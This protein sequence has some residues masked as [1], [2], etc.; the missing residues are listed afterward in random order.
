MVRLY[1][2]YS[3]FI[4]QLLHKPEFV[5]L[6]IAFKEAYNEEIHQNNIRGDPGGGYDPADEVPGGMHLLP[7]LLSYPPEL[8]PGVAGGITSQRV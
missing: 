1:V 6:I 4:S 7:H 8:H 2:S 3:S 5:K